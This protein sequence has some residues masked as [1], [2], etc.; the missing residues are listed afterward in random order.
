[1]M[2]AKLLILVFSISTS[3]LAG[4]SIGIGTETPHASSALEIASSDKGVLIPRMDSISRKGIINPKMSLMVFD[5]DTESFWWSDGLKWIE[6]SSSNVGLR[7]ADLD[8]KIEVENKDDEDVIRFTIKAKEKAT[9]DE[10]DFSIAT[11]TILG[12]GN[13]RGKLT[14]RGPEEETFGPSLF[15]YGNNS[16]QFES[17]RIRF[18]EGTAN[19]NWRGAY[20]HYN[21]SS[22]KLHLGTH[23]GSNNLLSDDKNAITIDRITSYVG[24]GTENPPE[25]LTIQEGNIEM[26]KLGPSN[27]KGLFFSEINSKVYGLVYDGIGGI[28]DDR[29]HIR[30]YEGDSSN[31]MT[32]KSNGNVG[33]G[34]AIPNS[35]LEIARND[36]NNSDDILRI[37]QYGSGD[38]S[39]RFTRGFS[40]FQ[41]YLLGIDESDNDKFKISGSSTISGLDENEILVFDQMG[42]V[43]I[44]SGNLEVK[45]DV[46]SSKLVGIGNRDL[47]VNENGTLISSSR[48]KYFTSL[49]KGEAFLQLIYIPVHLPQG[50]KI[51]DLK[52]YYIDNETDSNL[53]FSLVRIGHTSDLEDFISEFHSGISNPSPNIRSASP[54][55]LDFEIVDNINY[56]YNLRVIKSSNSQE[57]DGISF[58]IKFINQ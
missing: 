39:L 15:M 23:N 25:K 12:V 8:T 51:E 22:N 24:I 38:A 40:P 33:I 11:N 34:T 44:S 35:K 2:K 16:D 27:G 21:G 7:D 42:N 52:I 47:H 41:Q 55:I 26:N 5:I 54:P 3:N 36:T 56:S 48:F 1:M 45:G 4:Q 57:L 53:I 14:I 9:I 31:V 58:V 18:G 30:E 29:L 32:F 50:T 10:Q 46:S 19:N 17:G 20:I 43:E 37:S 49:I 13:A 6:I 28:G